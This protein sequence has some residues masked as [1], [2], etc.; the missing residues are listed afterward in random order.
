M[1]KCF[2]LV[3]ALVLVSAMFAGVGSAE[4]S[5]IDWQAY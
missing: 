2:A 5:Q 1:R 4:S 3:L